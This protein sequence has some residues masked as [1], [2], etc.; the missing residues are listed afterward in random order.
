MTFEFKISTVRFVKRFCSYNVLSETITHLFDKSF[1]H[2]MY[3]YIAEVELDINL[4]G[5]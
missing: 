1:Y 2:V 3:E 5:L 4:R